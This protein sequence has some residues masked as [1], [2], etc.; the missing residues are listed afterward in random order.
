LTYF[1][2]TFTSGF[3]F[4]LVTALYKDSLQGTDLFSFGHQAGVFED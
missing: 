1:S 4:L 3:S 2:T